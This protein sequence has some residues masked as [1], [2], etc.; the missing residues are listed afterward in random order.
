[1]MKVDVLGRKR[2]VKDIG[3]LRIASSG[4]QDVKKSPTPE[5]TPS[6][7]EPAPAPEP[8]PK[9]SAEGVHREP[10]MRITPGPPVSS[11]AELLERA[12]KVS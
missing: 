2:I 8:A 3:A 6:E 7:P 1:M 11:K 12:E 4:K 5:P 9:N 10:E